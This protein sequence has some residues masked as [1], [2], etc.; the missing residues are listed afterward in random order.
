MGTGGQFGSQADLVK[1]ED[2]MAQT[3]NVN[4][5]GPKLKKQ[6]SRTESK[7]SEFETVSSIFCQNS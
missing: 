5:V 6:L 4:N 1:N 3:N 7:R 2:G